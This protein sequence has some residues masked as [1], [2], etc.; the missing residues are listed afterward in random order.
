LGFHPPAGLSVVEALFDD[1]GEVLEAAEEEAGVYVVERVRGIEPVIFTGIVDY[2]LDVFG[3]PVA[4]VLSAFCIA[5][6]V[7]E[8]ML[9]GRRV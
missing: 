9:G 2:E 3:D 4:A 5:H 7:K 1:L 8:G 6:A